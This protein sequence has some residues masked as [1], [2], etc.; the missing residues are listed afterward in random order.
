MNIIQYLTPAYHT[1]LF[2]LGYK[3]LEKNSDDRE[4]LAVTFEHGRR[5]LWGLDAL[6]KKD[7]ELSDKVHELSTIIK[8]KGITWEDAPYMFPDYMFPELRHPPEF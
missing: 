8:E 6:G 7:Q 3:T 1:F 4:V 5:A 2:N